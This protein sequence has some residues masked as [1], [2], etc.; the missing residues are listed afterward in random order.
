VPFHRAVNRLANR[1]KLGKIEREIR[2]AQDAQP[3]AGLPLEPSKVP[4]LA[5]ADLP[6]P[7]RENRVIE[8]IDRVAEIVARLVDEMIALGMIVMIEVDRAEVATK[9][10]EMIDVTTD[11]Q[12]A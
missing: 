7:V 6:E 4:G 12:L 1:E 9:I 3:V 10:Q 5:T 2:D 8:T 11:V